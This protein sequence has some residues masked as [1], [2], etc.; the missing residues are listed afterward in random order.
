MNAE[1]VQPIDRPTAPTVRRKRVVDVAALQTQRVVD[2]A[3]IVFMELSHAQLSP[4][5][6]EAALRLMTRKAITSLGLATHE[7]S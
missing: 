5:L 3:W 6:E 2:A 1:P 7:V 4:P